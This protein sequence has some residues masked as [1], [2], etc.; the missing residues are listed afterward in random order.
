MSP[1]IS[2]P[3]IYFEDFVTGRSWTTP[4][5]TVSEEEVRAYAEAW[6]P[7]PTHIDEEA[8][9]ASPHGGL[10]ASGEHTFV[11]MRRALIDLG[12]LAKVTRIV[13][14]DDLRFLAPVRIGDR[15]TTQATCIDSETSEAHGAGQ[16][17]L[18]LRV[19]N[20]DGTVVL[21]CI[22]TL[23]VALAPAPDAE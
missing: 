15:L 20:Q 5:Q 21:G 2:N 14:Q 16:V 23:E 18:Q 17:T 1:E 6:D 7:L 9:A 22:D 12:V 4:T 3:G 11:I 10:I 19:I 13:K 8:A